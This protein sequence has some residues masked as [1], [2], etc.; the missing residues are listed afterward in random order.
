MGRHPV[1]GIFRA[2]RKKTS[3]RIDATTNGRNAFRSK[4]AEFLV[5]SGIK[6]DSRDS[7]SFASGVLS[8]DIVSER[9]HVR[10]SRETRRDE[11]IRP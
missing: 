1:D 10:N 4:D 8:D 2:R 3:C 7:W 9:T 5:L 6:V 11:M